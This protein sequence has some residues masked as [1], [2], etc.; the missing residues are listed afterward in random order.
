MTFYL[1][2]A[3]LCLSVWFVV[4]LGAS[5]ACQA[6]FR[7]CRPWLDS[8]TPGSW[9]QRS[10]AG[11][12]FAVRFLPVLL[13]AVVA[14]GIALPS[15]L[16]F[17]PRSTAEAMGP[18][19]TT[20]ALAGAVVLLAMALRAMRL[21]HA[22]ARIQKQWLRGAREIQVDHP[23]TVVASHFQVIGRDLHRE[24]PVVRLPVGCAKAA[25]PSAV[26]RCGHQAIHGGA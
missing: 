15:F 20:L 26:K 19:L 11:F 6:A 7:L 23:V 12:L 22:T 21:L 1:L 3:A 13:S 25:E 2:A 8:S 5:V 4:L 18:K 9:S 17:E 10:R 24:P 16:K 14:L